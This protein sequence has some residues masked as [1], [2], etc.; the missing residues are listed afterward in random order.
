MSSAPI[1]KHAVRADGS[2]TVY[3]VPFIYL[4]A[5]DL[6]VYLISNTSGTVQLQFFTSDYS[7]SDGSAGA[8]S[9]TF[10][11]GAPSADFVILMVRR[12][13]AISTKY[14]Y[15]NTPDADEVVARQAAI[16]YVADGYSV[17]TVAPNSI[18]YNDMQ[19]GTRRTLLGYPPGAGGTGIPASIP[20]DGTVF[21]VQSGT[22]TLVYGGLGGLPAGEVERGDGLTQDAT[23]FS[24]CATVVRYLTL[25]PNGFGPPSYNLTLSAGVDLLII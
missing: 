2:S 24:G 11:H 6:L 5:V 4:D 15:L 25:G 1:T 21:S 17:G 3:P 19:K 8:G 18:T 23:I 9:I 12:G 7:A 16:D 13:P 22:L 10:L 14:D 20:L